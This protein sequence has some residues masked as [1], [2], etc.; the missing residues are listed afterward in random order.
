MTDY[1]PVIIMKHD[2]FSLKRT[3][4]IKSAGTLLILCD[5]TSVYNRPKVVISD[6]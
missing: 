2:I 3:C 6:Q 5:V 4:Q 1:S